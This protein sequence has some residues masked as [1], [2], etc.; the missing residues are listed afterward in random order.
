MFI[1]KLENVARRVGLIRYPLN[2]QAFANSLDEREDIEIAQSRY[3]NPQE[4][5][6]S[7]K[8]LR[9]KLGLV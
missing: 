5:R 3:V 7:E 8:E 4:G 9:E 1:Q 6:L 2:S